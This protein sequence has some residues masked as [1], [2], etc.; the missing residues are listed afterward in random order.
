VDVPDAALR[1][2]SML[3]STKQAISRTRQSLDQ[4]MQ[5]ETTRWPSQTGPILM[6]RFLFP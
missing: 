6:D 2:M 5:G 4:M 3:A 1:P